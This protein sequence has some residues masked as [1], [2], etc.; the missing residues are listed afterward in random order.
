MQSVQ[1]TAFKPEMLA[2]ASLQLVA[3]NAKR[4][5]SR[6]SG[7]DGRAAAASVQFAPRGL[8]THTNTQMQ[9]AFTNRALSPNKLCFSVCSIAMPCWGQMCAC[10]PRGLAMQV[11]HMAGHPSAATSIDHLLLS[12][13]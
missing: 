10:L 11:L 3:P 5:P 9:G 2:P 4:Q 7:T 1:H 12:Q 13:W 6:V 8:P